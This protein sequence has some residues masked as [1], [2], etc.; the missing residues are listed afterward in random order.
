MI[1][2]TSA[3]GTGYVGAFQPGGTPE[4]APWML[5]I[6]IPVAIVATM[7]MGAHRRGRSMRKAA[8][9][10]VLIAVILT[11]GFC[12]A[13]ALPADEN[14]GS[15]LLLG[16]PLRAAVVIYG[17]GLLP[18]VILPVVYALT[19]ETHILSRD[20]VERATRLGRALQEDK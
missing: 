8:V 11:A 5:A 14:R 20:D 15:Q 7:V 16:L 2:G 3:I 18:V 13:L 17:I 9:P 6:G 10:F 19:F 12:L 1:V 4:W